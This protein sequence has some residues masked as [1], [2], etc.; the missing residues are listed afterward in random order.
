MKWTVHQLY[1]LQNK[2]LNFDETIDGKEFTDMGDEIRRVSDVHIKGR[3]DIS[4]A[5]VT[6]SFT[7]EG[8]L[9]LPCARTL[10]DV[11][12]P[13]SIHAN[14]TFILKPTDYEDEEVHFLEGDIVDLYPVIKELILLEV[15]MQVFSENTD[16]SGAAPQ[17][18]KDWEVIS[19]ENRKDRIDP[20]FAA[21]QDFFKDKK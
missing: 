18:G 3:A 11:Q 9:T 8:E 1:Q 5:R 16:V 6:F 14:E 19:E 4:S 15:P 13:F 20:R 10:V 7:V 2:G 21:L 17:S 12:Y